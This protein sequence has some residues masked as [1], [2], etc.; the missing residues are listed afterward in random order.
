MAMPRP[1]FEN[2]AL[3]ANILN[4]LLC[5]LTTSP[6]NNGRGWLEFPAGTVEGLTMGDRAVASL[7]VRICSSVVQVSCTRMVAGRAPSDPSPNGQSAGTSTYSDVI[8]MRLTSTIAGCRVFALRT[9]LVTLAGLAIGDVRA[10][11]AARQ[12]TP[13]QFSLERPIEA[14]AAPFLLAAA[15]G[16]FGS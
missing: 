5:R 2:T 14:A 16:L 10:Q 3:R 1:N 13:I 11:A 15:R 4:F 9:S 7:T 8:E 12:P 6:H